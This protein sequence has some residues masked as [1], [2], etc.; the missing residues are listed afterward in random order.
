M[1]DVFHIDIGGED[2]R[3]DLVQSEDEAVSDTVG[4]VYTLPY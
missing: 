1:A 2:V 3:T 4:G